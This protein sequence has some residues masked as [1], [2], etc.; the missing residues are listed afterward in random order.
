M[1]SN[2][3]IAKF[4]IWSKYIVFVT[5][6]VNLIVSYFFLDFLYALADGA[7]YSESAF[8]DIESLANILNIF[9]AGIA[10]LSFILFVTWFYKSYA[11]LENVVDNLEHKKGWIIGAWFVPFVNLYKPY[12]IMK[13][14]YLKVQGILNYKESYHKDSISTSVIGWWWATFLTSSLTSEISEAFFKHAESIDIV[15]IGSYINLVS[16]IIAVAY[17]VLSIKL[18]KD[19]AI[20]ESVIAD[21]KIDE[22]LT[23]YGSSC[24]ISDR[25][26][27]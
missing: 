24:N 12:K 25:K 15:I 9:H 10:I 14:M 11:N 27:Q 6:V 7:N 17:V 8:H 22:K 16:I 4:T 18:I 5:V 2:M 20:V 26:L 3:K 1:T 23:I 21:M 19:Y 13:D